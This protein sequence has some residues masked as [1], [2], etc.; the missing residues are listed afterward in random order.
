LIHRR[1][2]LALAGCAI[3]GVALLVVSLDGGYAPPPQPEDSTSA[4]P[5]VGVAAQLPTTLAA[6]GGAVMA[7]PDAVAAP[8][9]PVAVM[10]SSDPVE[11]S[12][13]SIGVDSPLEQL[14]LNPDGT[15]QVPV[16]PARPGWYRYSPPPGAR[17]PAVI[18]GH[19]DSAADGPAVFYRLG[20]LRPGDSV[21]VTRADGSRAVFTVTAVREF[22]KA[23]FPTQAVYGDT[24][25]AAL[26]LITCGDW[27]PRAHLY[28]GNTVVFAELSS[29]TA[30]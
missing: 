18:L 19:V 4:P 7:R 8:S 10:T 12:I 5:A 2:S 30:T 15:V 3:T 9:K 16:D 6:D 29:P 23:R 17:G 27:D 14:G 20:A 28:A 24:D 21:A 22:E 11:L 25:G 1:G 26:R 13:P